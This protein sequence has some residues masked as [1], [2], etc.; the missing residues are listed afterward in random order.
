[1]LITCNCTST[2]GRSFFARCIF[3]T[4]VQDRS[5]AVRADPRRPNT[6]IFF[7]DSAILL[8]NYAIFDFTVI[9]YTQ[10]YRVSD[11]RVTSRC[12]GLFPT[13]STKKGNALG[14]RL[15]TKETQKH[16]YRNDKLLL[17]SSDS[18]ATSDKPLKHF[19]YVEMWRNWN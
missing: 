16:L 11:G 3:H 9:Y 17:A 8:C 10:I 14:T 2:T 7:R 15:Q 1:M 19:F 13:A 4:I 18:H 6:E 5:F 12:H